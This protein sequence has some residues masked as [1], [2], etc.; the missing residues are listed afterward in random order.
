MRK[1]VFYKVV[2]LLAILSCAIGVVFVKRGHVYY[3][4]FRVLKSDEHRM[5]NLDAKGFLGFNLL[6]VAGSTNTATA[7]RGSIVV[8]HGSN[9]LL[10]TAFSPPLEENARLSG[11]LR[12][13]YAA[14]ISRFIPFPR[15]A[16]DSQILQLKLHVESNSPPFDVWIGYALP[17]SR[18]PLRAHFSFVDYKGEAQRVTCRSASQ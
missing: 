1:P 18:A 11:L 7:V 9:V 15:S 12:P 6:V 3:G 14:N 2:V 8:L 13:A 5:C 10:R 17:G 16:S 4:Y